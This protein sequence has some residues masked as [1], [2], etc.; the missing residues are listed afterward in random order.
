MRQGS[1]ALLAVS[2]AVVAQEPVLEEGESILLGTID[3]ITYAREGGNF[4]QD[5]QLFFFSCGTETLEIS[6]VEL[7]SGRQL[8]ETI[9]TT[10][11]LGESCG[12][13]LRIGLFP[14]LV[15][16]SVIAQDER[17]SVSWIEPV[18]PDD[19]GD[20]VIMWSSQLND[21]FGETIEK[22]PCEFED[23]PEFP[24]FEVRLDDFRKLFRN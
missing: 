18:F 12:S 19:I 17:L 2:A 13:L 4:F 9:R 15:L 7:L 22:Y 21:Q 8:P 14:N 16:M 3:S 1:L 11:R 20:E 10:N 23:A 5:S 6:G 24:C